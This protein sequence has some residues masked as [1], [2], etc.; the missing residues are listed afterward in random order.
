MN[1]NIPFFLNNLLKL[2]LLGISPYLTGTQK[3]YQ[4][5]RLLGWSGRTAHC[6]LELAGVK[7]HDTLYT[8]PHGHVVPP[9]GSVSQPALM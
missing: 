5:H 6:F 3:E 2:P 7:A 4:I 1:S 9:S 8:Q